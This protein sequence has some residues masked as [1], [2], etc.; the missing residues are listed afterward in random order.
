M[1][2]IN[3]KNI[4]ILALAVTPLNVITASNTNDITMPLFV[5]ILSVLGGIFYILSNDT[6]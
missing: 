2:H 5:C 6:K 1:K 4:T 3:K